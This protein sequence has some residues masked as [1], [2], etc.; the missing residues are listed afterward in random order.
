MPWVGVL[1]TLALGILAWRTIRDER[2][3]GLKPAP[4]P[5]RMP[6]PPAN[7]PAE[8]TAEPT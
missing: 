5:Q 3:P 1:V 4:A 7:A 2:A 6:A 8:P